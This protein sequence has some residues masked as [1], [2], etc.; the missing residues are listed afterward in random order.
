MRVTVSLER[1][2]ALAGATLERSAVLVHAGELAHELERR[3]ALSRAPALM[4]D[5]GRA[6][7]QHLVLIVHPFDRGVGALVHPAVEVRR[8]RHPAATGAP[9]L[10]EQELRMIRLVPR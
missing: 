6:P 5:G 9:P 1:L 3:D 2:E 4:P 8:V 7:D 10:R